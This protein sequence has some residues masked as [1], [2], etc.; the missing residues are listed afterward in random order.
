[1]YHQLAFQTTFVF[2]KL[3]GH[4]HLNTTQLYVRIY[5]ETLY[6]Q[7]KAAISSLEAIAVDDWPVRE[8]IPLKSTQENVEFDNSV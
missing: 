1:M 5:D 3:L 2:D 8:T 7:F 4:Q 6:K